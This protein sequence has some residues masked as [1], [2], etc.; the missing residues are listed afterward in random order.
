MIA[1]VIDITDG[2]V[3]EVPMPDTD[4]SFINAMIDGTELL[5]KAERLCTDSLL[6]FHLH[7]A[8]LEATTVL[9]HAAVRTKAVQ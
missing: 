7:R 4:E 3:V 8:L 1:K 6:K 9:A 5:Q 2:K